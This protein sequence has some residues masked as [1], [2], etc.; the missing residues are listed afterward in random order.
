MENNDLLLISDYLA[1][2]L[3]LEEKTELEIRLKNDPEFLALFNGQKSQIQVL[4]AIERTKTKEN[5]RNLLTQTQ[6]KQS[7]T[8]KLWIISSIAASLLVLFLV[9]QF[10]STSFSSP[11]QLAIGYLEP[12]PPNFERGEEVEMDSLERKGYMF[13]EQQDYP[14]AIPLFKEI[15]NDDPSEFKTSLYLGESLVQIG[16]YP[17]AI[18]VF[19]TLAKDSPFEDVAAWRLTL[20]YLMQGNT[21]QAIPLLDSLRK[22]NHY[23]QADAEDLF[24][25]LEGR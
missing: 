10:S 15:L 16:D 2:D 12:L 21:S 19:K 9:F 6:Q 4:K 5:L 23:K 24:R 25:L 14:S 8:R 13:Y 1:D 11:E 22:T 20:I 18:L 17:A 7:Q 3:S